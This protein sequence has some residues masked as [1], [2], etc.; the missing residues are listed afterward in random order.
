MKYAKVFLSILLCGVLFSSCNN[1]KLKHFNKSVLP[2]ETL[3][4]CW[5]GVENSST[6]AVLKDAAEKSNLNITL[7][8]KCFNTTDYYN[9]L[10]ETL[11][12]SLTP[13]DA[14]IVE[15]NVYG[16]D[17]I[18]FSRLA[19][20]GELLDLTNLLPL[21][22]PII[23]NKLSME[24][25]NSLKINGKI[26]GVPSLNIIT[27]SPSVSV[28]VDLMKKY[29]ISSINNLD[30]LEIYFAN[31]VKNDNYIVPL[32]GLPNNVNFYANLYGYVAL[33][34]YT[35]LVYKYDDPKMELIP[36]EDTDAFESIVKRLITWKNRGYI[37]IPVNEAEAKGK[38]SA[39]LD[40]HKSI[41]Q[42]TKLY[43]SS[44]PDGEEFH[45]YLIGK[46]FPVIRENAISGLFQ[47]AGIAISA[48]S[49]NAERTLQFLNWVQENKDNYNL[50]NYGI[51]GKDYT[52]EKGMINPPSLN[53][54]SSA[55]ADW[56]S[57]P[58]K[59]LDYELMDFYSAKDLMDIKATTTVAIAKAVYAPHNGFFP[60]YRYI[61]TDAKTRYNILWE[62]FLSNLGN[63]EFSDI[64]KI[65]EDLKGA[66]T[67][68]IVKAIQSQ[69]DTF[70]AN[71]K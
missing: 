5:I 33:D 45:T 6:K 42:N 32:Q 63:L 43:T 34:D 24:D 30:D 3:N 40:N 8:F 56:T 18:S 70:L 35:D 11:R 49:E 48:R 68:K 52:L 9:S 55:Y 21:N 7:N 54:D 25:I 69:L 65:R 57:L 31:V 58:F 36:F 67:E 60:D 15:G 22:A 28:S 37:K 19:K 13:I 38:V 27:N 71:K 2:H 50:L 41:E 51:E 16:S 20:E 61:E 14:F 17:A 26:Y 23:Y 39:Y 10:E 46:Q 64:N 53:D 4:F 59:N 1:I 66:G 44:Y 29:N 12:T 47:N 62:D